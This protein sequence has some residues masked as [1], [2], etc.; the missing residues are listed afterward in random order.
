MYMYM[1]IYGPRVTSSYLN[2]LLHVL[3]GDARDDS[4][5]DLYLSTNINKITKL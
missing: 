5:G 4:V 1:H 2:V 3:D